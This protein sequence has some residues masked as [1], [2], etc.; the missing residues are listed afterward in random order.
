MESDEQFDTARLFPRRTAAFLN[1][2]YRTYPEAKEV[3][4]L[5]PARFL[6]PYRTQFVVCEGSML[7]YLG[8]DTNDP[9]WAKIA[10]DWHQPNDAAAH[11]RLSL[12]LKHR[13][14]EPEHR[15][16]GRRP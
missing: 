11:E 6:F 16:S 10:H 2:W 14:P 3:L 1:L 5:H 7:E 15:A 8:I 9:D 4:D 13:F 12:R